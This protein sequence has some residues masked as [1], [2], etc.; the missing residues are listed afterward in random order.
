LLQP[1]AV[2][3][4]RHTTELTA[5]QIQVPDPGIRPAERGERGQTLVPLMTPIGT[6][7]VRGF[8]STVR[9]ALPTDVRSG[10][11]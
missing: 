4:L 10:Y 9:S 6:P 7:D 5:R 8:R 1:L 11:G 2:S 3:L